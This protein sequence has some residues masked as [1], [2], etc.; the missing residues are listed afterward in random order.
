MILLIE[1]VSE[2]YADGSRDIIADNITKA[3]FNE[4]ES[5]NIQE[6]GLVIDSFNAAGA[7]MNTVPMEQEGSVND[8]LFKL[9]TYVNKEISWGVYTS[10]NG[11]GLINVNA[12]K[13]SGVKFSPEN[14]QTMSY[15]GTNY[16]MMVYDYH[17]HQ[18]PFKLS[19]NA[20]DAD[21]GKAFGSRI[22]NA[23]GGNYIYANTGI[24]QFNQKEKTVNA[25]PWS[26]GNVTASS[27]NKIWGWK[28]YQ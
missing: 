11:N 10:E 1:L 16:N 6:N 8:F 18:T 22:P 2:A 21:Q 20:S 12:Y 9:S 5:I 27:T 23:V 14:P 17:T 26:F 25:K 24:F 4:T 28:K 15:N 19:H 7:I 3:V 13:N